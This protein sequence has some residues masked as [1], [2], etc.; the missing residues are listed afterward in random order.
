MSTPPNLKAAFPSVGDALPRLALTTVP[1]PVQ[2]V[3]L[4]LASGARSVLIKEDNRSA[5]LYGGNKVRKLEYLLA[6][7]AKKQRDVIATFGAAGSHH[8]LA[9]ALYARQRQ[10]QC[11]AFL[12]H[13]TRTADIKATLQTHLALGTR[14]VSFGGTYAARISILRRHLRGQRALVIPAGGSSWLGNIAF[15]DAAFELA[16]QVERGDIPLP[17]RLY[18]ATG[19]M[20]TAIGLALGFA[21]LELPVTV[22]AVRI[23]PLAIT[24]ETRLQRLAAK[25]ALMLHRLDSSF[26]RDL[27][28]RMRLRLRHGFFGS[29]YAHTNALTER[30]IRMARDAMGLQLEATYTGKAMA[31]LL[32]DCADPASAGEVAMFWQSYH[33]A[34]LPEIKNAQSDM[35]ALPPDFLRYFS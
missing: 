32:K 16:C 17:D 2:I 10:L 20:G 35:S 21:L 29:G 7:A 6:Q 31:A 11:I 24:D 18:V 14:L 5:A 19:T 30:A 34:P 15:I 26:P 13:Q 9:T 4:Q 27:A 22:H 1:T 25:T 12:S 8:A 33:A 23:T 28:G 3:E